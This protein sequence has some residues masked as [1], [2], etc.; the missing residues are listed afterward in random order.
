MASGEMG[1]VTCVT[2][3]GFF[4]FF[5]TFPDFSQEYFFLNKNR[6]MFSERIFSYK[7]REVWRAL[8]KRKS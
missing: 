5:L 4:F 2:P 3:L 6:F 8:K 1:C 7:P